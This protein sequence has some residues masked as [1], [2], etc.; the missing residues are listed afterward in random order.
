[1]SQEN[2]EETTVSEPKATVLP[3][4]LRL[5][6]VLAFLFLFVAMNASGAA[7]A[8]FQTDPPAGGFEDLDFT[9][10]MNAFWGSANIVFGMT[11]LV[12]LIALPYGINFA[13][14]FLTSIF[15]RFTSAMRF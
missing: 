3:L 8:G 9:G 2:K 7:A 4:W 11:G 12:A 15:N 6:P 14:Q 5:L 10:I 13:F 1:M